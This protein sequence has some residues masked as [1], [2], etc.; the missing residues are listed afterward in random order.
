MLGGGVACPLGSTIPTPC[1]TAAR[2]LRRLMQAAFVI[3]ALAIGGM[4]QARAQ[5]PTRAPDRVLSGTVTTPDLHHRIA[6]PFA[7]PQGTDRL[8]LAFYHDGHAVRTV[9]DLALSDSTGFRGASGSDKTLVTLSP[10]DA[11]PSY[12]AGPIAPGRWSLMLGVANIRAGV[13]TRWTARLWFL[14]AGDF[15]PPPELAADR[16]PGWYRGDL[17]LHTAHSDGRCTGQGA[18]KVP[19]PL[20]RSVETAVGRGLDFIAVTDHNTV[21]QMVAIRELQPAFERI[22]LIPGQEVTTFWGHF[23]A[24]GIETPI[25]Y[26]AIVDKKSFARA[27]DAVHQARGIVSINHPALPS[28]EICMGCGWRIDTGDI[29]VDAVEIVNGGT[30]RATGKPDGPLSGVGFWTGMLARHRVT[31]IGGSDNHDAR[32]RTDTPGTIGR[33]TTVVY[34]NGRDT[35]AIVRGIRSGRVFVDLTGESGSLID[36]DTW[37]GDVGITMGGTVA[38]PT[39]SVVDMAVSARL[40]GA[41]T[42]V[43]LED[44]RQVVER[45]FTDALTVHHKVAV[46]KRTVVRAIVRRADGSLALIGNALIVDLQR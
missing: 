40:P 38:A 22:L 12:L 8:I 24:I 18:E 4:H 1:M 33:P 15:Q 30:W 35:A 25:D 20:F 5:L 41:N 27:V 9:I 26:A 32:D 11:T 13:V 45:P 46:R 23:N 17:H 6:V 10:R 31:A 42:L 16:G 2:H 36:M 44:D 7:V 19:C 34:A 21:S 43:I 37:S 3:L 14:K 29:R 39:G 28:G